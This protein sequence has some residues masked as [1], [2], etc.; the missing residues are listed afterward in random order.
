MPKYTYISQFEHGEDNY[1]AESSIEETG[2]GPETSLE[3]RKWNDVTNSW[4]LV[5]EYSETMDH[6]DI[7]AMFVRGIEN[8]DPVFVD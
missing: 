1:R 3:V 2:D 8:P 6:D 7:V 5:K 4:E